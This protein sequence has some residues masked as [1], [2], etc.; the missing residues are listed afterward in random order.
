MVEKLKGYVAPV[1]RVGTTI[2]E[3]EA[4]IYGE[5]KRYWTSSK[6]KIGLSVC[7]ISGLKLVADLVFLCRLWKWVSGV[8]PHS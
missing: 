6:I 4:A 5:A 2:N 7:E 1:I 3:D 8:F